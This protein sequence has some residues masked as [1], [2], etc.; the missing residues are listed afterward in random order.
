MALDMQKKDVRLLQEEDRSL[1]SVRRCLTRPARPDA[2]AVYERSDG[3]LYRRKFYLFLYGRHFTLQCD[4]HP[5]KYLDRIRP[6]ED[7]SGRRRRVC[8]M[9]NWRIVCTEVA[10]TEPS[11]NVCNLPAVTGPCR[12]L[13]TRYFFDKT[14]GTCKTFNYGGCRGNSN[15]FHSKPDCESKCIANVP[16]P[17]TIHPSTGQGQHVEAL[18]VTMGQMCHLP[19]STGP[20]KAYFPS[21]FFNTATRKC[22]RFV[23]GGCQGNDNRFSSLGACTAACE[24][25][26]SG[27]RE[28]RLLSSNSDCNLPPVTG[29]CRASIPSF[30]YNY[31][32]GK[33]DSFTFGGC[34]GNANRFRRLRQCQRKCQR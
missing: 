5:L 10:S 2:V 15:N 11:E 33:C 6:F 28:S 14:D 16:L 19:R 9:R 31:N 26:V 13:K 24:S 32:T 21:Y 12:A 18:P 3:L 1:E 17:E 23:Y 20:C 27:K 34:G 30:Y 7:C 22:E 4:H 25:H 29:R 8:E